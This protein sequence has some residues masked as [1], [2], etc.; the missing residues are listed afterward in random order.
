MPTAAV[1]H[2]QHLIKAKAETPCKLRPYATGDRHVE[3][4]EVGATPPDTRLPECHQANPASASVGRGDT[5]TKSSSFLTYVLI[6]NL[7]APLK[8]IPVNCKQRERERK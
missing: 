3:W 7:L 1:I 6:W 8:I 2:R 4:L 5:Y